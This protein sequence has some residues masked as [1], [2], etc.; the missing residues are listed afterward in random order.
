M[1]TSFSQAFQDLYVI[2]VLK[3]KKDGYF[4]EIGANHPSKNNNTFLLETK[5]NWKGLMIKYDGTFENL[6]KTDRPNSNYV[7]N[8]ATKVNYLEQFEKYN[9]PVNMDYLQI[10][11]DVDNKSTLNVL[12]LLDDTILDKYKFAT[13]AFEHDIYRG[14]FFNT[15]EISRTI[16]KNKGYILVFPDVSVYW[17]E[18]FKPF[19]DWYVHPELV[20]MDYVNKIKSDISLTCCKIFTLL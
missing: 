2:N 5:Y 9:Y 3:N 15:R 20:D 18:G 8:D 4:L 6:Y 7:I 17:E 16:L 11:L 13:I 19:E 10:D 14:D 1:D 12:K